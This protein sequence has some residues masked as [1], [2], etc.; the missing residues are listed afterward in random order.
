MKVGVALT[1]GAPVLL[2]SETNKGG[3]NFVGGGGQKS[4]AGWRW[5]KNWGQTELRA[6]VYD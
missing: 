4:P 2:L 3:G 6:T 1:V 5:K